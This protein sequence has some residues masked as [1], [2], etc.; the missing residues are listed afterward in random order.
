M[1]SIKKLAIEAIGTMI[2]RDAAGNE[3]SDENGEWSVTFHSPGTKIYQKALHK[4]QEAKSG[5]LAAIMKGRNSNEKTDPEKDTRDLA[6]FLADVTISF[7][8]FDYE[9]KTGRPAF[10]AAY[11]DIEVDLAAQ[12]NKF[13]G[14][15]GN[16]WRPPAKE[17]SEQSDTQPG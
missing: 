14:D 7:N 12:G 15:R 10:Y 11:M 13:L 1:G 2:V 17:S 5:G 6:E 3:V 4:F 9:G 16:F 8:G